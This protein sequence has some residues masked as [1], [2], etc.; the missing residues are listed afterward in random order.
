MVSYRTVGVE[1]EGDTVTLSGQLNR[2]DTCRLASLLELLSF[3]LSSQK[4]RL[5]KINYRSSVGR[6]E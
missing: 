5:R 6:Q 4:E 1:V 2:P 3:K